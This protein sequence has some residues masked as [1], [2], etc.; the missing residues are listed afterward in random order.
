METRF[1]KPCH[2]CSRWHRHVETIGARVPMAFSGNFFSPSGWHWPMET[3]FP[4]TCHLCSRWHRLVETIGARVP[5]AFSGNLSILAGGMVQWKL[6]IR[7]RWHRPME[8]LFPKPCHLCSRW[9]RLVETIGARVPMAFSG[10]FSILAGGMVQWKLLLRQRWHQ[11]METRFPKPCHLCSRWH[12]HVETIGACVPM[13][14]SG[15]F[16]SPSGWH[17]PMETWF[18]KTCHLCP[19]WHRHVETIGAGGLVQWKLLLRQRWHRPMETWFPKTC[20]LCS[21]WDRHVE[22]IGLGKISKKF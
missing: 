13:A 18:P 16:F 1:P 21:R 10:N 14:F 20:H 6:L 15:N 22:I 4:K 17:W 5:M 19:R 2:L 12:W 8:T 3:W 7:Q 11:P 9:H